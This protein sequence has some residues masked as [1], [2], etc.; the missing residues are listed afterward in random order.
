MLKF[1]L[2]KVI[3]KLVELM[4]KKDT[5]QLGPKVF[6]KPQ[7]RYFINPFNITY[8]CTFKVDP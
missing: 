5:K 2:Q 1:I 6:L 7:T 3:V 4:Q 8:L